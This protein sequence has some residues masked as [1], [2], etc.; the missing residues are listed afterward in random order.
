MQPMK[1]DI[2]VFLFC[3]SGT[4]QM[5]AVNPQLAIWLAKLVHQLK[6]D[7]RI[8]RISLDAV[9]ECPTDYARDMALAKARA[10]GFDLVLMLDADNEPDGRVG[11]YSDAVPFMDV[12]LPLAYNR[13]LH[14]KPTLIA[15]PYS[16]GPSP[17]PSTFSGE[18]PLIYNWER[19]ATDDKNSQFKIGM[20][21][22]QEAAL[23][24]GLH[25]VPAI[26][27]GVCLMSTNI[28][29]DMPQPWFYYEFDPVTRR[30]TSTEDIVFSRNVGMVWLERINEHVV[31]LAADSWAYHLKLKRV[32]KPETMHFED[33][34][35]AYRQTVLQGVGK[36]QR[37]LDVGA[38]TGEVLVP[39]AE[40]DLPP[41]E[42]HYGNDQ[43]NRSFDGLETVAMDFNGEILPVNTVTTTDDVNAVATWLA[44]NPQPECLL[45]LPEN[46]FP[47]QPP[48]EPEP[49]EPTN[50]HHGMGIKSMMVNRRRVHFY[51][52]EPLD[53]EML[54]YMLEAYTIALPTRMLIACAGLGDS[55]AVF[56][57][58]ATDRDRP[59]TVFCYNLHE[60][61]IAQQNIAGFMPPVFVSSSTPYQSLMI[62]QELDMIWLGHPPDPNTALNLLKSLRLHVRPGGVIAGPSNE[63]TAL[64]MMELGIHDKV[65]WISEKNPRVWYLQKPSGEKQ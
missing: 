33:A 6:M 12:A 32:G 41:A 30:K 47:E 1:V 21:S 13:L 35:A 7:E 20:A 28:V 14:G 18:V 59:L 38:E 45:Q 31:F 51:E 9:D 2:A 44:E 56:A 24:T 11:K 17:Q 40:H 39:A 3:Y 37:L 60:T 63:N 55:A 5:G 23:M 52:S 34:C 50:P 62:P 10:D 43:E 16:S 57:K 19:T 54:R 25:R 8:G 46:I 65:T 36:G 26:A 42:C 15:A 49:E 58:F 48:E 4:S 64:A 53:L 61:K 22:R 29:D 27:T